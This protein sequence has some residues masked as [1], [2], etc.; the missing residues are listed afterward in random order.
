MTMLVCV[1]VCVQIDGIP[2][3][4]SF[5]GEQGVPKTAH[6]SSLPVSHTEET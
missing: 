5:L 1:C 6:V 3:S 4:S 2:E